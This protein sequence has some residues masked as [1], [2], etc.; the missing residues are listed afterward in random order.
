[1][2]NMSEKMK[3]E[4]KNN[5]YAYGDYLCHSRDEHDVSTAVLGAHLMRPQTRRCHISAVW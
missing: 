4:D 5:H 3:A 2:F 1:M